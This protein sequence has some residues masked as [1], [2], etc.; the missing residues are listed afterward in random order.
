MYI[1]SHLG[2]IF[3]MYPG[4]IIASTDQGHWLPIIIG[5]I[6]HFV[7]LLIYMKGLSF[8]PKKDIVSIYSGIGKGMT[9]IFIIPVLMYFIMLILITVRAYSEIITLV[10]L[11][12]TPLW[13]ITLLLLSISAYIASKG[14]EA[15]LRAGLLLSIL[16]L[17]IIIFT[18]ITSFQ[19]VDWRYTIPIDSDF[20]FMTKHDYFESFFAFSGGFLFLGFVQPYFSFERRGMFLAAAILIPFFIF[21]V[22]IPVLTFGQTTASTTFL[23][24]VVVLDAININWLMFDRVT[25]FF[26][27]SLFSFIM[28]YLSLVMWKAIRIIHHYIPSI[29]PVYL[30]ILLSAAVFF[31][32]FLIPDW[33]D[34]EKLLWWNTFL[35]FYSIIA[36]PLSLYFFGLTL[37]RK[38]K[39]ETI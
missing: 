10:F 19:N 15:V 18:F 14:I 23:P 37:K 7:S 5:V 24:Y 33:K 25:M 2:L 26:L 16:F 30:I 4:N 28:M 17:P 27:L 29:K 31:T 9:V 8:F 39:N 38:G 21:S 20:L 3:F 13:A 35:R 11:S 22:Y 6:V 32:C 36:V 1:L 12:H 34:V